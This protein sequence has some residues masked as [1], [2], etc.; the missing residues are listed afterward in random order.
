MIIIAAERKN[1]TKTESCILSNSP[2]IFSPT[3]ELKQE[4]SQYQT[5]I[6]YMTFEATTKNLL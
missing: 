2:W 6:S 4:R 5:S 3:K 1:N